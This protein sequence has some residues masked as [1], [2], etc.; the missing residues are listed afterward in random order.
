[1][2]AQNAS[3]KEGAFVAQFTEYTGVDLLN[4][5][6]QIGEFAGFVYPVLPN[7]RIDIN[8]HIGDISKA[9]FTHRR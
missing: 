2:N 7:T 6:I 4:R 8:I 1:M 5:P 9:L 3:L